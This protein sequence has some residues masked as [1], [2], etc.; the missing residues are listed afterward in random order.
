MEILFEYIFPLGSLICLEKV[1][2]H[3]QCKCWRVYEMTFL[4]TLG[5]KGLPMAI[6]LPNRDYPPMQRLIVYLENFY[7]AVGNRYGVTFASKLNKL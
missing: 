3:T 5:Q 6:H 2:P 7:L 4:Q 1:F